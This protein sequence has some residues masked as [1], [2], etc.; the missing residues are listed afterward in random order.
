MLEGDTLVGNVKPIFVGYKFLLHGDLG[1]AIDV[2]EALDGEAQTHQH[3]E[4]I[5]SVAK[6]GIGLFQTLRETVA[7]DMEEG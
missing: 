3:A 1:N 4:L 7:C 6:L 5:V 2:G